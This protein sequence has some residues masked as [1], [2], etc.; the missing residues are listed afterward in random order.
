MRVNVYAQEITNRIEV[1]T[2]TADNTG[3]RFVGVRFYLDSADCLK[4]PAHPDDDSSAVTFWIKSGKG[5][6]KP[7]DENALAVLFEQ[8]A[9]A[10]V[11]EARTVATRAASNVE[12]V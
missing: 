6:F 8:A 2:A 5:G 4:P 9:T 1:V 12:P 11:A 3:A 10:L 7:G